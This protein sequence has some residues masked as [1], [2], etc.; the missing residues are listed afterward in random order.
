M[1]T[2]LLKFIQILFLPLSKK[3]IFSL[4]V[5]K[6]FIILDNL[7]FLPHLQVA[8]SCSQDQD[9]RTHFFRFQITFSFSLNPCC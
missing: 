6:L 4:R 1:N 9:D 2:L 5:K 8:V 7:S 3:G